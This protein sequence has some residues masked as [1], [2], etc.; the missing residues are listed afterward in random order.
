MIFLAVATLLREIPSK[1]GKKGKIEGISLNKVATAQN[2]NNWVNNFLKTLLRMIHA[3]FILYDVVAT[4]L[5]FCVISQ[6][7]GFFFL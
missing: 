5:F 6:K 1:K 4:S 2:I 3:K 7:K